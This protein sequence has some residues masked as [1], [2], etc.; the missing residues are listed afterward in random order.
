MS[1]IF[2]YCKNGDLETLKQLVDQGYDPSAINIQCA[3]RNRHLEVVKYL[4]QHTVDRKEDYFVILDASQNGH[5]EI[6]KYLVS[7]GC[8]PKANNNISI[9][10]ASRKGH[11][12]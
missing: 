7:V 6:V 11:L 4:R 1:E 9:R 5:L 8:D 10:G 12:E 3:S 2:K